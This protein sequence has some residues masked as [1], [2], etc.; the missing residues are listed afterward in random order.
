MVP[1][2]HDKCASQQE[3]IVRPSHTRPAA[4]KPC[5]AASVP[6]RV[7]YDDAATPST[8]ILPANTA[9]DAWVCCSAMLYSGVQSCIYYSTHCLSAGTGGWHS[10]LMEV[11]KKQACQ[12][13]GCSSIKGAQCSFMC[14][15]H[16]A[17]AISA[18]T[19]GSRASCCGRLLT[20]KCEGVDQAHIRDAAHVHDA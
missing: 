13:D 8:T 9:H 4:Q 5:M 3:N 1:D 15:C 10:E 19:P 14:A 17:Q 2:A 18:T 7:V 12:P 11:G 16:Q 20:G 6:R